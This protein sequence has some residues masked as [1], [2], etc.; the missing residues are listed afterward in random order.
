MTSCWLQSRSKCMS[1]FDWSLG[2]PWRPCA[3][4][5]RSRAHRSLLFLWPSKHIIPK[6]FKNWEEQAKLAKIISLCSLLQ[7]NCHAEGQHWSAAPKL[8]RFGKESGLSSLAWVFIDSPSKIILS[9]LLLVS[10]VYCK[11][12]AANA[13]Y[14]LLL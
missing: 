14:W 13:P 2:H 8:I 9:S 7:A 5:A 6:E 12:E 11:L 1:N 4:A 3:R 10:F